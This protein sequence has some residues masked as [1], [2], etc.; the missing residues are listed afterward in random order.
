[1][2]FENIGL[3]A[4]LTFDGSKFS[5][6]VA[7]S[8]R[9]IHSFQNATTQTTT[10]MG[11]MHLAGVN[12]FRSLGT[13]ISKVSSGIG[14][15][16]SG[17]GQLSVAMA[18]F[19]LGVL[20]GA[21]VAVDFEQQMQNVASVSQLTSEQFEALG[22]KAKQLGASTSFTAAQAGEG[23][24]ELMRA[25][26]GFDEAMSAISGTLSLAAAD[27][28][29]LA[30]AT[31]ITA[32]VLRAMGLEAN[33]ASRVADVLA[34]TSAN[35]AT[36][37]TMLGESFKFAAPVARQMGISLEDTSAALGLI[38]NAG[39][40]GTLAGNSF[41]NML[42]K[43][44]KPTT[45]ATKYMRQYGISVFETSQGNL[46]LRKTL[47]S[48]L[49]GTKDITSATKR[50]AI[51]SELFGIEGQGAVSAISSAIKDGSIDKLADSIYNAEGAAKRMADMRLDSF[52]GQITLLRSA[53]EGFA[54]EVFDSFVERAGDGLKTGIVPFVSDVVAAIQFLKKPTKEGEEAFG[55]LGGTVKAIAMGVLDG[56]SAIQGAISVVMT[57]VSNLSDWISQK[58]GG[59][60]AQQITKMATIFI[61]VAAAAT[62]V[63]GG[64]VAIGFAL[65]AIMTVFSG[66]ASIASAAF[67]PVLI[68]GGAI[69][70]LYLE[71]AKENE[72]FGETALRVWGDI[73]AWG[74]DVWQNVLLPIWDG[75]RSAAQE[76]LPELKQV[77]VESWGIIKEAAADLF[78]FF[79]VGI[80][81]TET[82]WVDVGQTIVAVFAAVA[83]TVIKV[84]TFIIAMIVTGVK[85]AYNLGE[86]IVDFI[87]T[88]FL[89]VWEV[90]SGT[91]DAF[92]ALA[93]GDVIGF[94]KTIGTA[95]LNFVLTPLNLIIRTIIRLADAIPG[96]GE[97]IPQGL[98]DFVNKGAFV[99]VDT[100]PGVSQV[101]RGAVPTIARKQN[102]LAASIAQKSTSMKSS[103]VE[104]QALEMS[105]HTA[106][107]LAEANKGV[108]GKLDQVVDA[109]SKSPCIDN[110]VSVAIDNETVAR[111][112]ARHKA[113]LKE[114]AGFNTT[115]WQRRTAL[116][117]GAAPVRGNGAT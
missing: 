33:Q 61:A 105:K 1:M 86:T 29:G 27:S 22:I 35:S 85:L 45:Q 81:E 19:T 36:N 109:A 39:I 8:E 99:S 115:P 78:A 52:Q 38:S 73:K 40:K 76:V 74:L 18:P 63:I 37:V 3:G 97:S 77:W 88:P 4:F 93:S 89:W 67:L 70:L 12:A 72:S 31:G 11:K 79:G 104:A 2:A 112:Q 87:V 54:I 116:E 83:E 51:I 66:L 60:G 69:Y 43:L 28:I 14:T 107:A 44:A 82:N 117:F 34:A 25:G 108:E 5:A 65:S 102:D 98:R 62:P 55:K 96:L 114:R 10:L 30:E 110:N 91:I 56:I 21:K 49:D 111:G 41:K 64:I 68:I 47:T 20:G 103:D 48:V 26:F 95:I 71:L 100:A 16:V 53:V 9:S 92:A 42:L 46:D 24:E 15:V 80:S 6:G 113:E 50:A 90:V 94:F 32:N 13:S 57:Q 101:E 58:L 59:D 7:T 75:I 17:M 23:F 106:S 84:T